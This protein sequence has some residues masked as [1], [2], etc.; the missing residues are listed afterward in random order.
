M[1]RPGKT[2]P[3]KPVRGTADVPARLRALDRSQLH[4]VLSTAAEGLPYSSLV[5]FALTPDSEG[6]VFA[7]PKASRKYRNILENENVS[8]LIDTRS[9]SSTDYL[10]AEAITVEGA[11]SPVRRGRRRE[12]LSR[13]LTEKHPPLLDFALSEDTALVY[14]DI[15]SCVHV[16][17]FQRVTRWIREPGDSG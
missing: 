14:V 11:A 4:A 5:A 16:T 12:E 10:V 2:L 15:R 8:L 1:K 13:L 7:T 9:N 3:Q 17:G 6:I